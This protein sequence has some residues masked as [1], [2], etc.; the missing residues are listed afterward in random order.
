MNKNI[1]T[2]DREEWHEMWLPIF[3]SHVQSYNSATNKFLKKKLK[4]GLKRNIYKWTDLPPKFVSTEIIRL[5]EENGIEESPFDL[6]YTDRKI[7]GRNEDGRTIMLWEH[8]TTNHETYL[9]MVA[10]KT[11]EELSKVMKNHSGVCWI[12]RDE[13]IRLNKSGFRS[14]RKDG[15][16]KAYEKCDI[17]FIEN[18]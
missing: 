11:Q 17:K 9:E 16:R 7:L 15:W 3:W 2:V 10:C 8:T 18:N 5:F 14:N 4:E 13:D 12:T 1:K 6:I